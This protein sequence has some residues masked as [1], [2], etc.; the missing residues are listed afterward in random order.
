MAQADGNGE[1]G[2]V[3]ANNYVK[4]DS[5]VVCALPLESEQEIAAQVSVSFQPP[6]QPDVGVMRASVPWCGI[7]PSKSASGVGIPAILCGKNLQT[8]WN[9]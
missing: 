9:L 6:I 7:M 3:S 2:T 4:G 8:F 1:S 5:A